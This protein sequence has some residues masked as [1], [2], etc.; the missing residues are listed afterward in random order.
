MPTSEAI[1]SG[2]ARVANDFMPVSVIWHAYFAAL[3]VI[4]AA[5]VRPSRRLAG[6]AL[7][8][9]LLSVSVLAWYIS[10]PFNG[11]LFA[12]AAIALGALSLMS[13]E[14]RVRTAPVAVLVPG[15]VLAAFGW[16]YP[17]FL[18][19]ASAFTYLYA[20][21]VGAV[22][23]PTLSIVIG[24]AMIMNGLSSR[25]AAFLLGGI[26]LFYG[27]F[28]VFRL[29]VAIDWT[30]LAGSLGVMAYAIAARRKLGAYLPASPA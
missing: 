7:A 17:H 16:V 9:P 1:L 10:N 23:C 25:P 28:G 15:I 21:P 13:S 6:V 27:L 19:N 12:A 11:L 29:G 20:A 22:P 30:L 3:A 24:F 8:L 26:G 2:L 4:L 18:E 14:Q 5:G